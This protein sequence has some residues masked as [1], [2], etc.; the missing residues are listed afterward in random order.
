MLKYVV[1]SLLL[2]V[3]M[4]LNASD[5]LQR[6]ETDVSG[7][8][9]ADVEEYQWQEEK[10]ALPDF[11]RGYDFASLEIIPSRGYDYWIDL[12]SIHI[13][14]VDQVVRFLIKINSS[15]G[16]GNLFYQGINCRTGEYKQYAY[17]LDQNQPLK[18]NSNQQW[19]PL[20]RQP[21]ISVNQQ[22]ADNYFCD[23]LHIPFQRRT[24]INRIKYGKTTE[25]TEFD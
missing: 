10:I 18:A 5:V 1:Y 17:G 24:L 11:S 13:G 7:D 23:K 2:H 6:M 4:P 21:G 20:S 12:N 8:L 19:Q 15:S 16:A 25:D 3:A 14:S 22:L 9:T